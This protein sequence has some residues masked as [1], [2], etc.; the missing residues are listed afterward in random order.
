MKKKITLLLCFLFICNSTIVFAQLCPTITIN[1]LYNIIKGQGT[2][3][4]AI[5]SL[6]DYKILDINWTSSGS[7]SSLSNKTSLTPN[8]TGLS[9]GSNEHTLTIKTVSNLNLI[10]N[11]DFEQDNSNFTSRYNYK[12]GTGSSVLG[13]EGTYTV[14]TNPKLVHSAFNSMGDHTTGSGKMMIVNGADVSNISIWS[15]TISGIKPN[16]KYVFSAYLASCTPASPA[17]L[18]F[19]INRQKIGST[20]N[21]AAVGVWKQFYTEW[22]SGALSGDVT[23]EIVNQQLGTDGNDF[24][25]DDLSFSELCTVTANTTANVLSSG[26]TCPT[27]LLNPTY[28]VINGQTIPL[29]AVLTGSNYKVLETV[30][31]P[32]TSPIASLSNTTILNPIV[33]GNSVGFANYNVTVSVSSVNN[34]LGDGIIAKGGWKKTITG[35]QPHTKYL[36]TA[37]VVLTTTVNLSLLINQ[38]QYAYGNIYR[39]GNKIYLEWD[40]GNTNALAVEVQMPLAGDGNSTV[41]NISVSEFCKVSANTTV[42]VLPVPTC[43]ATIS[44]AQTSVCSGSQAMIQFNGTPNSQ[45]TYTKNGLIQT[46]SLDDGGYNTLATGNLT[47]DTRYTLVSIKNIYNGCE[48][49][50]TGQEVFVQIKTVNT[51]SAPSSEPNACINTTIN[52][53]THTT[54]GATGIGQYTGLPAGVTAAWNSNTIT[55]SGKPTQSGT[56]NY[57]IP[58]TGGCGNAAATGKI[59]VTQPAALITEDIT[60]CKGEIGLLRAMPSSGEIPSPVTVFTGTWNAATDPKSLMPAE[61]VDNTISQCGFYPNVY[62]SYTSITFSVNVSATY[63]LQMTGANAFL[64]AGYIYKGNYVM[65]SCPGNGTWVT[66]DDDY[67]I[68]GAKNPTL[69]ANLEVGT[70]Y[71]LVSLINAQENPNFTGGYTWTLTP[72]EGGGFYLKPINLWYTSP[73]GGDPIGW[74]PYLNPVLASGSGITNTNAALSKTFYAGDATGCSARVPA[75]FTI[76]ED[77]TVGAGSSTPNLCVNTLLTNITH[78]T[79]GATGIKTGTITKLPAGVTAKWESNLITISGTPTESGTFEY[80]IP[81]DGGCGNSIATGKITVNE[82]PVIPLIETITA[83]CLTAGTNKVINYISANSYTFNPTGPAVNSEGLIS[84]MSSGINYSVTAAK[85]GCTSLASAQFS[86]VIIPISSCLPSLKTEVKALTSS[87]CNVTHEIIPYEI[88]I[89]NSGAATANATRF[90]TTLFQGVSFDRATVSYTGNATGPIGSLNNLIASN[91]VV[92]LGDFTIPTSGMVTILLYG[93]TTNAITAGIYGING[94]SI[95]LDPTRTVGSFREITAFD[96]STSSNTTYE[97]GGNVLG[98]N[99]SKDKSTASNVKINALPTAAISY[100]QTSYTNVG[101]ASIS[102]NGQSG[103]TYSA[104]PSGLNINSATGQIN[105]ANS[106]PNTYTVNYTFSNSFS[107]LNTATTTITITGPQITAWLSVKDANNNGTVEPGEILTFTL[108]MANIDPNHVTLEN[109]VGSIKLP[110]HTTLQGNAVYINPNKAPFSHSEEGRFYYLWDISYMQQPAIVI[111]VKADCDLTGVDKIET[112][113]SVY[114]NGIEVKISAPPISIS[115]TGKYITVSG[116]DQYIQP[117]ELVNCPD[118]CPTGLTVSTPKNQILK[119]TNPAVICSGETVDLTAS[120]ITSGSTGL[121]TLT[122]FTDA[123]CSLPL[124]K[125]TAV[126]ASGTYYIKSTTLTSCSVIE[127]VNV[128]V[129]PKPETIT[130]TKTICSGQKYTWPVNGIEYTAS[131]TV[132]VEKDGCTADQTLILT[133]GTKPET[134]IT[135]ENICFGEKYTWAVNNIEYDQSTS[136]TVEKDGCTADQTLILTVGTK[137]QTIITTENICFGEKYTWAINGIEYDQSTSITVENDGCTADQTLNLTIGTKPQTIITTEN[138]CFGEKYIW[139]VN[140]IEY[141]QSTS[142]TVEK[143]GCTADQT[144]LLTVGTKPQTIVTTENI[145]F[146]EKYT[147]AVNGIEYDQST[148]ITV[149]NDGCT[150][151]QTLILTVG[152]KPETIITTENICFG[153]KYTWAVNGIEYDQSTSVTV[154]KDGCTADQSLILTI[155]TKPQTIVTTENI[156]FGEKYTWAVNNIEYTASETVTVEKDGCTADQTLIL[157]VGTKPQTIITTENICFGEKYTWAV[158]NIEYTASETVTVEKDGCTADQTLILTVGTKP[159]TI[160]TTENICFGEKYTWA[161]N[162]IEYD[163]STSITVEKD[164]CTA[165]QTLILTVGTKPQTVVTTENICFDEKYTWAV[166]GIEYDQSTS[167]TVENDGCTADQSLILTVGT[168]P[169][170][171]VTTENICFGEKYTWAV[172][173]IEYDQSTS[174][175]VEKDGCTADQSLILTVGTKPQTIVTTKNICFGEK[176]TWAVNNIEYTTSETVT[177]EKDGCTADQ[178]LILTVG[179]KPETIITTENICYGQKYTWPINGI[180]YDQSTSITVEKDGCTADQTLILTVGTKP[181]TIITTE[182]ICFGEKYTWAINGIE[183]D[184][185]TSITVEND[186]CTADQS[187]ILT[188]GT[189]PQTIVTTENICFGEKYTWAINGIEYDQSTSITVESD[190]C[191]ADQTLNLTIGTKPQTIVTTENICFGEK[192]TWAVNNIEYDQSTSITVEKDGCTA[193]QSLI[194]TVG[195]KPQTIVTTENICFGEKYTWAANNIE[196]DQSTS[197]TMENN[198]CTADQTLILTVGTK[199]ETIITTENICYGQKYTWPINGIEYDQSTSVT[200]E[201]N[202]CTADQAL[203]LTVG[204]KPQTIITTENI[205]FGEKYTWAVNGIEYDQSTSVTIEKDGCTADQ[206]LILTV[207][208]KPQTIVTTE[209]ICSGEKYIWAVNGIEYDQSTS[210]TVEKDG[211]TADQTLILTV[212]TKPQTIVTTENIC[213]GEKYTWAVNGVEYD[214]NTSVTIEKDGCTADQALILT[215]ETKPETIVTTE[216]ICYGE[217]YTWAINGI[218]YDQSTSITVE[219]DGCTADQ[220]LILTVGTK[221]Q[222]IVTT[223]NICFGEK[224]TWAVNNIEYDQS[225]SITVEKDGC[226][227]DQS[228]ILTVGTKPQTIITTENICSGEKYIWAVNGIEYDQSTSITVEKDGCTADQSLILTVGTKPQTIVTTENICFG[229]KYTWAV[230]GIEYDQSTSVT[231]ENNGCTADQSLILTVGTKP[232]TIVTTENICFGEKYTWAINGIE[233]DQSTSITVEKDG[234]TADQSLIL[235]VGTKPQTI[236]TTENICYGQKYTWPINGI[237]YDQ[238]TSITVENDGCTADQTLILT[239]GTKP[240]TIVTTEN[241]CFGEKFTWAVNGIEYD[242]STSITVEKDG[243]TADQTLILT[244]GTKPQT[245]VTTENICYGQKYTWPI[246][247]IEYDQS[248]SITVENDGCTADQTLILTVGTKPQTIVTTENICFGE[249]YTWAVNGIEYDQS[250]SITVEKDGC[251][252]DQTLILTVGT[253]PQ[254]VVTTENICFGEKYTWV[255]NNIEYTASETVTVEK[256]GCT[257]DQTLILTV[258]TKPQ[259]IVTTENICFGEKYTWAVNGIEYTASETVTVEKDGCTAD[260]TLILTVGTKPQTIVTT[261][262]ICSGATYTWAANATEY[263]TAQNAIRISNDGCTADQV[264]NLTVGTKPA[265]IITT[266]NICSGAAYTWAANGAEYTTAQNGT[267]ISN[268]GCTAD[269]VLN[270]TVGTKPAD[271]VTTENICSGAAYIWAA[272]R[273][274]YTTAQNAIRISNDG[275]TADQVLNLTVGTK[276]AD[277]VTTENICSGAAYTWAANRAAYTTAQNAIRISNDGCTADQVLKLTVTAKPADI[278]TTENICFGATYTWAANGTEY[279]TAQNAIRIS[280]DGCTADQILNLT[281]GTKPADI[282]TTENICFGDSFLWDVDGKTYTISGTYTKNNNGCTADQILKLNIYPITQTV[283]KDGIIC[284]NQKTGIVNKSYSIDSK[285]NKTEYDFVWYYNSSKIDEAT[286]ETYEANKAGEYEVIAINKN[287]GCVSYSVMANVKATNPGLELKI[288]Q[289]SAFGNDD[290]SIT[291]NVIGGNANY[292]YQLDNDGFGTSNVIRDVKPGTHN[293]TVRDTNGCTDL[294]KEIYI[295]GYPKFFTPNGDGFND[296]WNIMGLADQPNTKVY[297]YDRY[298]K[299]LKQ[300]LTTGNGWDGTYNGAPLPANDYWFTVEYTEKGINKVFKSHF[301]LKR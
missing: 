25:L 200:M 242:Q 210:I 125:P 241:I 93:K 259:T 236:V 191:T 258:G 144:L 188:V 52:N 255:V 219:S 226:T 68:M 280:N 96:N 196:Y 85:A 124:I 293:I 156:C 278:V 289:T 120:N 109:V 147:W 102:L 260:Q 170:T 65:G 299:L 74:G 208:T 41:R 71:T 31:T 272:N 60:I 172:N 267:R 13:L 81:L 288:D 130:T 239:V 281:V 262:N 8:L 204:T 58:L 194:L 86:N 91:S 279:T 300:I 223:E 80:S 28:T 207:G 110:D 224:Y 78:T 245:I 7:S 146:G 4:N 197:V 160:V 123:A 247:G 275:C 76:K 154:E 129:N 62:G 271:I 108:E 11:G 47:Q 186:G 150:A 111:K 171:I 138:I 70:L 127:V 152:T 84:G 220:S 2:P 9:E 173:G 269:Q 162:G 234:C 287:T 35:I 99:F 203:I 29:D 53:I 169:Q 49:P 46:I 30:W 82:K 244:V 10:K 251:T 252:A 64:R 27:L 229:E 215:V 75:V 177:V 92:L 187:L 254:T 277:I 139:S 185:S 16:T 106:L 273:N 89:T 141:D 167:I 57:S 253:K 189:K 206:T 133:V 50:I 20:L 119:I 107:C 6:G 292:E 63:S 240:Q 291:I 161:I 131:E 238:S 202:G 286:S 117:P 136:I 17:I 176:Y 243:C 100:P 97:T 201:N 69:T 59:I 180:E 230:N 297:I 199:P 295:I 137:P 44:S 225:T 232:Q 15:Q 5:V 166:N 105:L 174:I 248:T 209:N 184:Q 205:C 233:Y 101:T 126:T 217:K 38:V 165:D 121:G 157:T 266:E 134:I 178:T 104:T 22:D 159:Q 235:T 66:G 153:E 183:Y 198:G 193:D 192:Y 164:G 26:F 175:T 140:G 216:N 40:S 12:S 250:T 67:G 294:S 36:I 263:T 118:G 39:A 77:N 51:V 257:A 296:T 1:S 168:K 276:P 33:T 95:Y 42:N 79:A 264:L 114:I 222:T 221:P 268:D 179:T 37:D 115:D 132:T 3:I 142:I 151:D 61:R 128:T 256:D 246:N 116:D 218:E 56:F 34:L 283:L 54:T 94:Q 190:G 214:Q 98:S 211:C 45:I 88:K 43:N 181:E 148:S 213:F 261:E 83:T 212:G 145:C 21:G 18:S 135:T 48:K 265:D 103:G 19:S 182:N 158:N 270:L 73:T 282:V 23:I 231:I 149:E 32:A 228:L 112:I 72:P 227:A 195:T 284:I 285:L 113:G 143:D 55:I 163:Q 301:T 87:I 298:G 90:L 24:A 155:G 290:T 14:N 249:K 237:E 274:E 122:Y